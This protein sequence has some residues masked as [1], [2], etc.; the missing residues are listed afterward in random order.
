LY[1]T[2]YILLVLLSGPAVP[3]PALLRPRLKLAN[4]T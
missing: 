4:E 1:S 2:I 3:R